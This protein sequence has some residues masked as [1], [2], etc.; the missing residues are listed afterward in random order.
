[1]PDVVHF[2][3]DLVAC[4]GARIEALA[5]LQAA[6][7]SR[8]PR[9]DIMRSI[10]VPPPGVTPAVSPTDWAVRFEAESDWLLTDTHLTHQPVTGFIGITGNVC[11]WTLAAELV[12]ATPVP[13]ILAGGIGPGNV[14]DGVMAVMPAGVDSCTGTNAQGSDSKAIRFRKDPERVARLVESV[15]RAETFLAA[16]PTVAHRDEQLT[17]DERSEDLHA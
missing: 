10:P 15:R 13:V 17:P 7:R 16:K 3:D 5:A 2:C 6:V 11:D 4:H 8:F 14:Y 9:M 12:R 1:M